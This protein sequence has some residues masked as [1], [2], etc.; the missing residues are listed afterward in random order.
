MNEQPLDQ[1]NAPEEKE[2]EILVNEY[3]ETRDSA[4]VVDEADRTVLLTQNETVG[5]DKEQRIDIVPTDRPRK[6]YTGM[7]GQPELIT[8]GL[9]LFA[10][11][12]VV[13]LYIF[14][15]VPA[16]QELQQNRA[17]RDKLESE[18]ASARAK[19]GSITDTQTHVAQLMS[20][21]D[22]FE[23]RY[24]PV[25]STGRTSLYQRLNGLITGHGL[26]NTTGPEYAP[27]ETV[28]QNDGVQT[29]EERGRDK[30]RSLF[31]GVYVTITVE[32]Y[33]QNLRRFIRDIETTNDFIVVSAVELEPSDMEA[34]AD[35]HISHG[36]LGPCVAGPGMN[37]PNAPAGIQPARPRGKTHGEVV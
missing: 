1:T 31:P 4:V 20:N 13:L 8:L 6:V 34:K 36:P 29:D 27:L 10:V 15:V 9:A 21:V 5:I 33:Y 32:G 17:E 25:V 18:L 35:Q 14:M 37:G 7:W 30:Y 26:V 22:D 11:L 28:D 12:T 23:S 2:T 19:Y 24:L 16:N 3:G